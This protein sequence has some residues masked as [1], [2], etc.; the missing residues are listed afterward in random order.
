MGNLIKI[1]FSSKLENVTFLRGVVACFLLERDL[2][3]NTVNEI[4][5]VVSEAVTNAIVH[6]YADREGLVTFT[7]DLN[8]KELII[9]VHD[10]GVGIENIEKAKEPLFTTKKEEERS[11]LGFT[12]M[13]IFSDELEIFSG[14]NQGTTIISKKYFE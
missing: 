4:K 9:T 7:M 5:T 8:D 2:S 13:E 11:G 6:G 1:E 12:I 14:L 3:V 10:D